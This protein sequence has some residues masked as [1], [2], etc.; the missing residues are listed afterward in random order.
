[1]KATLVCICLFVCAIAFYSFSNNDHTAY[2]DLYNTRIANLRSS[3]E[4]A[5]THVNDS[6]EVA[7]REDI[8]SAR[9]QMKAADIWLRYLD[10]L[11]YKQVNSPL[12]VEWETEVFEKFEK[13]YKRD[14]AGLTLAELYLDEK[15]WSRD[16]LRILLDRAR[17][18]CDAYK[19]DSNTRHLLSYHH[20]FLANRLMLLNLAAIYTTGFEC[21]APER[22]V[23]ELRYM[24]Q[25]MQG[26]YQAF[27]TS[28][29]GTS[30]TPEYLAAFS[31]MCRFVATQPANMQLFDHFTFIRDHVNPL[32]QL[33]QQMIARYGVV[34]SSL[35]DYALNKQATSIF[36]K[37]LYHG[38]N[39]KGVFIRVKD[40]DALAMI[41]SVGKMLFNDPIL[42]GNNQRSCASCHKPDQFFTDTSV[43]TSLQFDGI[44][45]LP[46]NTPTLINANYNH[47]VMLDGKHISLQNQTV[48]VI[49]NPVEMGCKKED[50]VK[51]VMACKAYRKAFQQLLKYTPAEKEVTFEHIASAITAYYSAFSNYYSPFDEAI[52]KRTSLPASVKNG[53][54]LFMGKAQ[55]ATC[56][57]VPQ[58]N[59]VKP[60]YVGSEF[61]VLGVPEQ[62]GY[63]A[64]S[65]DEGRYTVNPAT[66]TKNAFRTGTVR[67][68]A[69]TM[70]YM[71]N[72]V[73]R[74]LRDVIDFYDA[75]GGAGMGISVPNQTLSADSL[76]LT[77]A[78]KYDLVAFI[79]SLN[80][81]VPVEK[82]PNRLP[83]AHGKTLNQRKPGGVY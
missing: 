59:G 38:Q 14:G 31:T 42:S 49:T 10:P 9:R 61:E 55:C 33:N 56:H 51:K 23:P 79:T 27:N 5:L 60:P 75:G 70:P 53:F 24:L 36:D 64:L 16:S 54:N 29:P 77:P 39:A 58:F 57:F 7:L 22:V 48:D 80:E 73:F 76:H 69:R 35:V 15:N 28:F 43:A 4:L 46:R 68:A 62:P 2:N 71:H 8:E 18:A 37:A 82:T 52:N 12:P 50:V 72:G 3:I 45:F 41:D 40:K 34:S 1:M 63:K 20:F 44:T 21:P 6:D 17:T 74:T 47:L 65:N 81:D 30:F 66:E 11:T 25:D 83:V 32:F 19:A 67:N 26:A 13:P 78:E